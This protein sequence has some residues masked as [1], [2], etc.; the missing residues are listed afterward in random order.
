MAPIPTG[1]W[2]KLGQVFAGPAG[3][4]ASLLTHAALPVAVPLE[5]D[6]V[7]VFF[8][9]R[10]AANR[11][12]VGTVLIRLGEVPRVEDQPAAPVL[13]PGGVGAF[14]DAGVGIG[15]VVPGGDADRLYYMGWNV[16]GSVPW[17]NAIGVAFGDARSGRFERA[18]AGPVLDRNVMD[19]Y[20]L[21]YPWVLQLGPGDWRMWYG[22]HLT[23]G[24]AI[25]DMSHAIRHA[26]SVDGLSWHPATALALP[27]EGDEVATVRPTVRPMTGGGYEMHYA[28]RGADTPY[29]I[30]RAVSVDGHRWVRAGGGLAPDQ[31]GWEAGA[32]TYPCVFEQGGRRWLLYN[33]ANYGGTGFGLAVWEE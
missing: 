12:A 3:A 5:G 32:T 8:S 27:P 10:D 6:L 20:S 14:D 1:R 15:C 16:G 23:W 24:A 31:G 29:R 17:R 25:A 9:G 7:R 11:S 26:S 2:R 21:S 13:L 4:D 28:A 22:T 18:F 33:G 30:G 19:P